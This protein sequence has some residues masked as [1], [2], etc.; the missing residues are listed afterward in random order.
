MSTAHTT[1]MKIDSI[2]KRYRRKTMMMQ[3][4]HINLTRLTKSVLS[5]LNKK[6]ETF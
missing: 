3:V 1:I 5:W 6:A 4:L 2:L